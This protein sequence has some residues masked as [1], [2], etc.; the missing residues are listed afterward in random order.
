MRPISIVLLC[1]AICSEAAAKYRADIYWSP[2]GKELWF[3]VGME[4]VIISPTDARITGRHP[5]RDTDTGSNFRWSRNT[6]TLKELAQCLVKYDEALPAHCVEIYWVGQKDRILY[7]ED[8]GD[9][10]VWHMVGM[11]GKP[12][13]VVAG[14]KRLGL[15]GIGGNIVLFQEHHGRR[16]IY[17]LYDLSQKDF[18][19]KDVAEW[20]Y[21]KK[22]VDVTDISVSPD[23][24]FVARVGT[25]QHSPPAGGRHEWLYQVELLWLGKPDQQW[26]PIPISGVIE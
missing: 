6:A 15:S 2:D 22:G 26:K 13:V 17:W 20:D 9:A 25:D 10:T 18:A 7:R 19:I 24:Q 23:G 5:A 16:G 4:C 3:Q 12:P 8:R 11:S 14:S 1:L 21:D